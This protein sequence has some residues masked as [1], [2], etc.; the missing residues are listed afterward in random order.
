[1]STPILITLI[2]CLA[3]F[4][5]ILLTKSTQL[6]NRLSLKIKHREYIVIIGLSK[7]GMR[8]AED[9][10]AQA[11]DVIVL[12]EE[13]ENTFSDQLKSKGI[14]V[15]NVKNI[16]EKTLRKG[17]IRRASSCL[18]VTSNEDHNINISNLISDIAKKDGL[19]NKLQLI[20]QV[21]NWYSRNLLIDQVSAFSS[22]NNLSIIFFDFHHNSAKLVYDKY[23]PHQYINDETRTNNEKV[24][25]VIGKNATAESFILENTI[26]SQYQNSERLKIMAFAKNADSWI[27]DIRQKFPFIDD[28]IILE[29]IELLNSSF[30]NYESWTEKFKSNLLK[31]DAAYFFGNED[32]EIISKSLYFKQF[33]YN[34][35]GSLRNVPLIVVIPD[36]TSIFNLLSKG[37]NQNSSILDRYKNELLIH[38]VREVNDSCTYQHLIS[39]NH[40]EVQS[41]AINY[42]YSI[43]YEFDY[44]LSQHFKK[45]NNNDIL[46]SLLDRMISFKVKRG[47]PLEQIEALITDELVK[48][49]KNSNYRVKQYFG[50]DESWNR[51]TERNKDSN[52]YIARH[53]PVKIAT[54][55]Q[56][57]I[58]E[59]TRDKLKNYMSTLAPIEHNRWSA[60]KFIAGFSKGKLPLNDQNLKKIVKN[61]LKIHD[62]VGKLDSLKAVDVNQDKD[63]ELF[64]IIPL[65]QKIRENV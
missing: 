50:I 10:K 55:K 29:P 25:C 15:I 56:L 44:L 1:M 21:E 48:Y 22:T 24:I 18:I 65:L 58:T 60:E 14:P 33:L 5:S 45:N 37:S 2:V 51:V 11:K 4:I 42:F 53:I 32:A 8:I 30:S 57:N 17:K 12:S 9:C 40:I 31:I 49:T 19:I 34:Q 46:N 64:L 3:L 62:Q 41:K 47:D 52:R 59:I 20:V 26:L 28:Y 63:I 54:L 36:N 35:T 13:G 27:K 23:P 61:T 16:N 43:S 7:I 38:I 6:R 39:Q